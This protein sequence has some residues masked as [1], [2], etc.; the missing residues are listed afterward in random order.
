MFEVSIYNTDGKKIDTLTVDEAIFGRAVNVDLVKQAVVTYRANLRHGAASGQGRGEVSGSTRK[1]F[2]QKGTG[3]ARRGNI[4]TNVMRGGGMAFAKK[5]RDFRKAF[6]KKM[7]RAALR[8]AILAKILGDDLLIVRGMKF[9]APKTS[10][11]VTM[12]ANLNIN[13]SCL[14]VTA[15]NDRNVYLSGRNIQEL[16]VRVVEDI[17]AYDVAVRQ[18]MLV[19]EEAMQ[20][21]IGA[22]ATESAKVEV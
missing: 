22:G 3:Y 14:L 1:I 13:R 7:K 11:L 12:L 19:T 6:P 18:K 15:E 10:A 2:R 21:L 16:I 5:P 9:D 8:S 4:R 20:T 17:N